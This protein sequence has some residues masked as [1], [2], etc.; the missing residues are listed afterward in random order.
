MPMSRRRKMIIAIAI[1]LVVFAG[2]LAALLLYLPRYVEATLIPE[3]GRKL[4]LETREAAVRKMGLAGIDIGPVSLAVADRS[5]VAI[6][7]LRIDYSLKTLLHGKITAI[8][9]IG[10]RLRCDIEENNLVV[11]GISLPPAA[12][13]DTGPS[14][15]LNPAALMPVAI[16]H[17]AVREAV[18]DIYSRQRHL[19]VPVE[20]EINTKAL[21]KGRVDIAAKNR[22]ARH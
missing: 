16:E 18:L 12:S 7:T 1:V 6:D 10:L 3:L 15:P 21:D 20:M 5:A 11:A 2:L 8:S 9:L 17:V 14:A 4:G 19:A 13:G 22:I